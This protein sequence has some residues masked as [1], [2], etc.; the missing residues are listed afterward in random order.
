LTVAGIQEQFSVVNRSSLRL[1][2]VFEPDLLLHA[3]L[4]SP[5]IVRVLLRAFHLTVCALSSKKVR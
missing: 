5:R 1:R 3:I 4:L 2:R